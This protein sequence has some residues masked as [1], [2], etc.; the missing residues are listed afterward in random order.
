MDKEEWH[1]RY[2]QYMLEIGLSQEEAEAILQAGMGDY[3]YDSDP[4]MY[5]SDELSYWASDG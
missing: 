2:T 3:D 4:E 1:K 5:A